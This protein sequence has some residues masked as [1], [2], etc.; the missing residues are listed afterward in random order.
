MYSKLFK[1]LIDITLSIILIIVLLPVWIPISLVLLL[2]GEHKVFFTQSRVGKNSQAFMILK[3]NTMKKNSENMKGGLYTTRKDPRVLPFG[4][5]LRKT[6]I[7]E[8][9]QLFHI[10]SG[11]MSFVGPRPLVVNNPYPESIQNEIYKIKPGVTGLG[12]IIFRDEEKLLSEAWLEPEEF[13]ANHILPYKASLELWYQ[14]NVTFWIDAKII[15]CTVYTLFLP[16][17]KMPFILFESI[18]PIPNELN[19]TLA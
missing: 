15:F 18:P 7:D 5:F 16:Y 11:K 4:A 10:L 14:N 12:S 6:K 1:R 13:Y 3:H 2:T 9:P 19:L 8:W 17:N